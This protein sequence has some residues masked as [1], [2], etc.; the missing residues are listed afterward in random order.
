MTPREERAGVEPFRH[1]LPRMGSEREQIAQVLTNRVIGANAA[2]SR[3]TLDWGVS[4]GS[5]AH[6]A[7]YSRW[8]RMPEG[9]AP[10]C[11][12]VLRVLGEAR[13]AAPRPVGGGRGA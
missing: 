7:V 2:A 5:N 12:A 11:C 9:I 13:P 6:A 3:H 1:E 10:Q 4:D 8:E